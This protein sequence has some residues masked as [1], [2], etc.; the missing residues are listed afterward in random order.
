LLTLGLRY[1]IAIVPQFTAA[2]ARENAAKSH[3]IRKANYAVAK[4]ALKGQPHAAQ[5]V[6]AVAAQ[7]TAADDFSSLRLVR[8]REEL[9]RLDK[10]LKAETD[11]VKL[12]KLASAL[13]RL[14]EQERQLAGRPLPG[15][16]RPASRPTSAGMIEAPATVTAAPTSSPAVQDDGQE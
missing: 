6:T 10:L 5:P 2:T 14:A 3:V 15:S 9:T 1:I 11:P 8:V 7:T 13:S 4:Q 16:L 12:D